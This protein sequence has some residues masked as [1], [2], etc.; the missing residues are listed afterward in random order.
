MEKRTVFLLSLLTALLGGGFGYLLV[1][2]FEA[3]RATAFGIL[4]AVLAFTGAWLVLSVDRF[5]NKQDRDEWPISLT[6]GD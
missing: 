5:P 3:S 2:P 1:L 6:G 4:I